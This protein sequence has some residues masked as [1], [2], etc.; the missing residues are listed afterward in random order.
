MNKR[1]SSF[2]RI[3]WTR[4]SIR[5]VFNLDRAGVWLDQTRQDIHQRTFA[6]AILSDQ[7]MHFA[8]LQAKVHAVERHRWA[9]ALTDVG[10]GKSGHRFKKKNQPQSGC[11]L[12]PNVAAAAT[13]GNGPGNNSNRNAV[14]P[15]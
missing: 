6:R 12:Q 5:A 9:K 7:R 11:V 8:F 1:N 3:Q 15:L 2:A 4:R 13:L 10:K 14:A